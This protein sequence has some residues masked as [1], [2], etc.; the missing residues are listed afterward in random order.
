MTASIS[1]LY[2]FDDLV[3]DVARSF[4]VVEVLYIEP[5]SGPDIAFLRVARRSDGSRPYRIDV[6]RGD[7]GADVP[8]FVVG[9][10]A[11]APKSVI[12]DQQLMT[13]LYRGRYDVKRAAPG[14]TMAPLEGATRH[15]CTTLGGNSG[16]VVLDLKTGAAVGLHF[17]SLY[18]ETNYAVR[19]SQLNDYVSRKRWSEPFH[20]ET[21]PPPV[22]TQTPAP[23]PGLP[24]QQSTTSGSAITVT[25][26]LSITVSLDQPID[27]AS[28]QI[29]AR[30][31]TP[32]DAQPDWS[33]RD[34]AAV[35]TAVR[36]FW[37]QR[38]HGVVAA[39]VGFEDD[40]D[41]IGDTPCI[42]ASVPA[43]RLAAVAAAGPATFEGLPVRYVPASVAEQLEAWSTVE[44][45]GNIAY[46]IGT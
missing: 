16:S 10:P 39:R 15:D 12:P 24:P 35:E 37:R 8:V 27:L 20:A 31:P 1:T 44:S 18:Q 14:F 2:E 11:R 45:V 4:A 36:R 28:L 13:G 19:A 25:I 29:A 23:K 17:A 5:D 34:A 40:G 41:V 32:A 22:P 38:P 7:A 30:A 21:K 43:S 3:G 46:L 26:P 42:S 6:A 9:Y 33:A